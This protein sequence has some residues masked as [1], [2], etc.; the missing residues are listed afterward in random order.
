MLG[1]GVQ[2]ILAGLLAGGA[3]AGLYYGILALF[4]VR[5]LLIGL[6]AGVMVGSAVR[7][8][9]GIQPSVV[10]R[11]Y[12]LGLTYLAVVSTYAHVMLELPSMTD[13]WQ[14]WLATWTLPV[15][16]A[17]EGKNLVTLVLLLLGLYEAWRFSAPPRAHVQGP[18]AAD[19][20]PLTP[21]V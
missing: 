9:R 4:E 1:S 12:A 8:F 18:F 6:L 19:G 17:A 20:T 7:R 13:P 10:Y 3:A 21:D 11:L 14:A 2:A 5:F 15:R 16:M